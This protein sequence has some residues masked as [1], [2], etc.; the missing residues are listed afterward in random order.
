[1]IFIDASNYFITAKKR[2]VKISPI[3]LRDFFTKDNEI[4]ATHY[5]S[6]EDKKNIPQLKYH[7]ILQNSGIITHLVD[8][9][10][11]NKIEKCSKCHADV[12]IKTHQTKEIDIMIGLG[13]ITNIDYYDMIILVSGDRDFLPVLSYIKENH[14][15][16]VTIVSFKEN[17]SHKYGQIADKVI[18]IDNIIEEVIE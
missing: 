8:L 4:I 16:K 14:D 13:I 7:R 3:K 9:L 15:K 6:A 5:Y 11:R 18:F 2:G 17:Y 1:M 10:Y 12:Q